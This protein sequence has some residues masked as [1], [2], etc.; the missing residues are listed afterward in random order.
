MPRR[1]SNRDRIDRMREEAAATAKEKETKAKP[2]AREPKARKGA[3]PVPAGRM[4]IVWAVCAVNG[5]VVKTFPYPEKAAAEAEVRRLSEQAPHHLR[6][7][8]VPFED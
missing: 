2:A 6:A 3:A 1:M 7:E 5:S 8:K 4:K